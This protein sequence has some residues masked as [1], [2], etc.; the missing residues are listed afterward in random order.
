MPIKCHVVNCT[1]PVIAQGLCSTHYKRKQRHNS[2]EDTR[3]ADWGQREKHPA[4]KTWIGLIR[5]H[6]LSINPEWGN[7]FWA[8]VADIPERPERSRAHRPNGLLPWGK[9][10]FYWKE[11]RLSSECSKEYQK[12]FRVANPLYGKNQY[13]KKTYG[14][15]LDWYNAKL[16][17]QGSACAICKKPETAIIHGNAIA[18]SVDHCHNT[19]KVRGLLCR[20]CNNALGMLGHDCGILASAISYLESLQPGKP[21]YLTAPG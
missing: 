8:F 10:N 7:D 17:E 9:D 21:V 18:L 12:Q 11:T 4:Y 6:H 1:A 16:E 3:P 15:D 14:V 2:V 20:A 13:L 19:G 5:Y